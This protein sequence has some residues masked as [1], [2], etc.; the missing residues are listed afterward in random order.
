MS[1]RNCLP[2][3]GAT[4]NVVTAPSNTPVTAPATK[5]FPLR[6]FL[7]SGKLSRF[8]SFGF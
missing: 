7:G 8:L 1:L 5:L 6:P 2:L 3:F 4:N